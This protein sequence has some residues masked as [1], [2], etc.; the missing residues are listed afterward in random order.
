[1]IGITTV[2]QKVEQVRLASGVE[3]VDPGRVGRRRR[4]GTLVYSMGAENGND[5]IRDF[6]VGVDPI[7]L[8]DALDTCSG[9]AFGSIANPHG[10]RIP[11]IETNDLSVVTSDY[12]LSF[13]SQDGA[14]AS[15]NLGSVALTGVAYGTEAG[16]Q[17]SVEGL[18]G[19]G[20]TDPALGTA[21]TTLV[22]ATVNGFDPAQL[23]PLQFV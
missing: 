10:S 13:P 2:R 8:F 5:V 3:Q 9:G 18:F 22:Y 12:S 7:C 14:G 23:A 1:L 16:Q 21:G 19:S 20:F 11:G 6:E 17:D 4:T 15:T